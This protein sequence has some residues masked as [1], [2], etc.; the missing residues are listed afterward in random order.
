MRD[1]GKFDVDDKP[2]FL[3]QL[4]PEDA[5][6]YRKL[7]ME[8]LERYSE[9]FRVA[10]SDEIDIPLA[11]LATRL[12]LGFTIGA[13]VNGV[14]SGVGTLTPVFGKKLS[15]KALLSG[16]YVR[17]KVSG[18]G[19]GKAIVDALIE[20]AKIRFDSVQLTV[21]ANNIRGRRLYE[22]CGFEWYATEPRSI[23]EQS[24]YLDEVYM[25]ISSEKTSIESVVHRK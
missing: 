3:R 20:Y 19:I 16:M 14:L 15:H 6:E 2:Y 18:R 17:E 24:R 22:R 7:R 5:T 1:S 21:A 12:T 9:S 25:R 13:F 23:R 8:G 10:P 11:V 4:L